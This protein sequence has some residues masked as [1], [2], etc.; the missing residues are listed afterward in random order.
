MARQREKPP[1]F[2]MY[3]KEFLSDANQAG[4]SLQESGAYARLMC[5]EWN[6][7]G[8]GLP[9]DAVRCGYMV[10]ATP[11]QMRRMWPALRGCFVPHQTLEGRIVHPRLEKERAKQQ[12]YRD[13]QAEKGRQSAV[14]RKSTAVDLQ[15]QP[16][17][18]RGATEHPTGVQPKGKSPISYLLK[19]DPIEQDHPK[20]D[21][22]ETLP[23]SPPFLVFP[24]DGHARE[25]ALTEG[26]VLDWQG[27]YPNLDVREQARQA[28]AWVLAKPSNRKTARGMPAFLVNWLNRS[29][30]RGAGSGSSPRVIPTI[31]GRNATN[32]AAMQRIVGDGP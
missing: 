27:L 15:G 6:E 19:D 4:M 10:G 11:A 25:W 24:T 28:L 1:A 7:H 23:V 21:S 12:A 9:D 5:Y 14:N 31:T 8:K 20:N 32:L 2:Q 30:N 17:G 16:N 18:N 29:T 22:A 26:Q 13:E 3:A